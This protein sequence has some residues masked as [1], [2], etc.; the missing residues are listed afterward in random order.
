WFEFSG[1]EMRS[2]NDLTG[3]LQAKLTQSQAFQAPVL[4][5]VAPYLGIQTSSSFDQGELR[6]RLSRGAFR[7][8]NLTLLGQS[9]RVLVIGT[10]TLTGRLDLDV[11]AR[12]G[13]VGFDPARLAE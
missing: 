6:A 2:L 10:V 11:T 4:Y 5:Q 13:S 3:T 8:Q 12:T 9:L 7:I 1:N